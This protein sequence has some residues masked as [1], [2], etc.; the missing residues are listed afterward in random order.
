MHV[1][2][3]GF[4]LWL[5]GTNIKGVNFGIIIA[6]VYHFSG[7][8]KEKDSMRDSAKRRKNFLP[9]LLMALALWGAWFLIFF[10]IP[11]E[12]LLAFFG[13]YFFLFGAVFLTS[14]L[15][16]AHSRRGLWI[17]LK[18]NTMGIIK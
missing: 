15:V 14:A 18:P 3:H 7:E 13:F 11:P 9:T 2:S 1:I 6:E 10:K 17:A 5:A 8:K 4:F 12:T 16:L